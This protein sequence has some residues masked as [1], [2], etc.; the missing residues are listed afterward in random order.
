MQ[1]KP[2]PARASLDTWRLS[3]RLHFVVFEAGQIGDVRHT[4]KNIGA[5]VLVFDVNHA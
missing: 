2:F 1:V 5:I 3:L 4:Q